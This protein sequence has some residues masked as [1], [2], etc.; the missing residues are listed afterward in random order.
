MT[1]QRSHVGTPVNDARNRTE[2]FRSETITETVGSVEKPG[3]RA[4]I[5]DFDSRR[6]ARPNAAAHPRTAHKRAAAHK[7]THAQEAR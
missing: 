7:Y 3:F 5:T 6:T 2:Q 1:S 4:H